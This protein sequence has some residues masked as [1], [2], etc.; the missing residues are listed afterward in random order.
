[1]TGRSLLVTVNGVAVW[2]FVIEL[3]GGLAVRLSP[4]DWERM[5]LRRGQ[6]VP[7]R[8]PGGEA[9]SVGLAEVRDDPPVVWVT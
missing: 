3:D 4:D 9:L 5:D 8:L 6:R 1:M 7:V 2:A